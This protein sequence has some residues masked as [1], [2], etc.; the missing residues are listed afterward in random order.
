MGSYAEGIL[1]LA[2]RNLLLKTGIQG[3]G[4]GSIEGILRTT[5]N[6]LLKNIF[7]EI[8]FA[9]TLPFRFSLNIF[10]KMLVRFDLIAPKV[11][12]KQCNVV[13]LVFDA[14]FA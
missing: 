7:P 8:L 6:L 13:T 14:S 12:I 10:Q 11:I 1:C 2:T 5:S 9:K 4:R 3:F